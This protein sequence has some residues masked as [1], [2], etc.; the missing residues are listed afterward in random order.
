MVQAIERGRVAVVVLYQPGGADDEAT[1]ANVRELEDARS[2]SP[3]LRRQTAVFTDRLSNAADYLG[4]TSSLGVS[5]APAVFMLS[6]NGPATLLEGYT[7]GRSLRQYLA[8]AL[9]GTR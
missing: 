5:Q 2:E 9:D 4:V 1:V 8:D 3:R 6:R 7:D